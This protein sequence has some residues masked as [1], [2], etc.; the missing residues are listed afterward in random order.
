[1]LGS[2]DLLT[3][4]FG[5]SETDQREA[6]PTVGRRRL[7]GNRMR[8]A[9]VDHI[10]NFIDRNKREERVIKT[11]GLT[12]DTTSS[13]VG[14]QNMA[15]C[16][17]LSSSAKNRSGHGPYCLTGFTYHSRGEGMSRVD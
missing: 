16:Q 14:R 11:A 3:K 12:N 7:K 13:V 4:E 5:L 1:M 10:V 8:A 2:K 6:V 9:I 15:R 17:F